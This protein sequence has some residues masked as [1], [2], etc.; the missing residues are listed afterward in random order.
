MI[1][2]AHCKRENVIATY[3]IIMVYFSME[4]GPQCTAGVVMIKR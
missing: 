3:L 1:D 2:I 4:A